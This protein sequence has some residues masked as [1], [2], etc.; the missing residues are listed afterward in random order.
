MANTNSIHIDRNT[1]EKLNPFIGHS[2]AQTHENIRGGLEF[3]GQSVTSLGI[4][5]DEAEGFATLLRAISSAIRFEQES[6]DTT[7]DQE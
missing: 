1:A 5:D 2:L 4:A 7:T 6:T 3:L